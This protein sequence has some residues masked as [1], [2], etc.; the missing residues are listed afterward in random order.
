MTDFTERLELAHRACQFV[1]PLIQF[2][3]QPH[4]LDGDHG[5]VGEG[6]EKSDLLV[7]ERSDFRAAHQDRSNRNTFPQQRRNKNSP[8]SLGLLQRLGVRKLGV[9]LRQ[10]IG[11]VNGLSVDYGPACWPLAVNKEGFYQT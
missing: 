3:E 6:F 1:G 10:D 7:G 4:V 8:G 5:L 11:D 9:N 2:F